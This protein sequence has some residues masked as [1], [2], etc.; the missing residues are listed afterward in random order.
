MCCEPVGRLTRLIARLPKDL[1][2]PSTPP[3][4]NSVC[5]CVCMWTCTFLILLVE[6]AFIELLLTPRFPSLDHRPTLS[7]VLWQHPYID[8]FPAQVSYFCWLRGWSCTYVHVRAHILITPTTA[9]MCEHISQIQKCTPV[10]H[11]H[12]LF[13]MPV[14]GVPTD[15]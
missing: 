6:Y 3:C 14:C 2:S 4:L 1:K 10:R 13:S 11:T 7:G 12:T 15:W 9:Y 8:L 5:V